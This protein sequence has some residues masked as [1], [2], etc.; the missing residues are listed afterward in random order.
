MLI[1]DSTAHTLALMNASR[2]DRENISEFLSKTIQ[3]YEELIKDRMNDYDGCLEFFVV[4]EK[5]RGLKIGK[6]LWRI[7]VIF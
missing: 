4:S 3:T 6:R 2:T 1:E 5:A 7:T